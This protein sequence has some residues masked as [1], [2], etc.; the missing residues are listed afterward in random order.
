MPA[1]RQ[2]S[3]AQASPTQSQHPLHAAAAPPLTSHPP[4]PQQPRPPPPTYAS[5]PGLKT[6]P[7][8]GPWEPTITNIEPFEEIS[9]HVANFLFRHVVQQNDPALINAGPD[10]PVIEIEA[11]IGHLIDKGTNDRLRLPVLSETVFNT[12]DPSWRIQFRSSM[13]D[14]P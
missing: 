7:G 6:L 8:F 2:P 10:G 14:V 3:M 13:T 12:D 5:G 4:A 9:R 11:K 1:R